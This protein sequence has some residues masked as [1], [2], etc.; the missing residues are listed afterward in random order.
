MEAIFNP[1]NVAVDD[2]EEGYHLLKPERF[3][4]DMRENVH[5][6]LFG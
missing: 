3:Y 1:L 2:R 4:A 5:E 6:V